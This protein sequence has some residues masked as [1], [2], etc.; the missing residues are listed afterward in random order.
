VINI[1]YCHGKLDGARDRYG[2]IDGCLEISDKY[3]DYAPGALKRLLGNT[4]PDGDHLLFL[5]HRTPF[6]PS[7][8]RELVAAIPDELKR[9]M[10]V[11]VSN[12]GVPDSSEMEDRFEEARRKRLGGFSWWNDSLETGNL[13]A[14]KQA[15]E[16]VLAQLADSSLT[17]GSFHEAFR[18]RREIAGEILD[19][20]SK[21]VCGDQADLMQRLGRWR[22]SAESVPDLGD[23]EVRGALLKIT[24]ERR[25]WER[26]RARLRHDDLSNKIVPAIRS[27]CRLI[28]G[29]VTGNQ[30]EV[31]LNLKSRVQTALKDAEQLLMDFDSLMSPGKLKD[32]SW[33]KL[34]ESRFEESDRCWRERTAPFVDAAKGSVNEARK[35]VSLLRANHEQGSQHAREL[36]EIIRR[37]DDSLGGLKR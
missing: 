2:R 15:I 22:D 23:V 13:V 19:E 31:I 30:H 35:I 6:D 24:Q 32:L 33:G 28:A 21:M 27:L 3:L 7:E 29:E 37:L 1:F 20:W 5:I 18:R 8:L 25:E 9:V 26:R 4:K 12:G 34:S 11:W 14:L 36:D 17:F 10:I 16:V